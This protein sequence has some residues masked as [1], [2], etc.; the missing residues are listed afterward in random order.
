MCFGEMTMTT[1]KNLQLA[2]LVKTLLDILFGLLVFAGAGLVLWMVFF[3]LFSSGEGILGTASVPVRIGSGAEPQFEVT[4]TRSP[5]EAIETV[6]VNEAEGTLRLETRSYLPILMANAAKAVAGI[7][8]AYV[9]YLLRAIV[10]AVLDGDPFAIE[11]G[12][13]IRRLG[14]AVLL[15]SLIQ[16]LVQYIAAAEILKQMPTAV[17]ALEPGPTFNFEL[18]LVSLLI[19]LLAHIWSYGL[20]LERERALTI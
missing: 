13:R 18:I 11:N 4:F 7:G 12:R 8:V 5:S 15:V 2:R 19:L 20:D 6:F 10:K 1:T 3:P 16:D 9:L 14:F 17:P